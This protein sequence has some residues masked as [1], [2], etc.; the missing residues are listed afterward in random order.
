MQ[1]GN[2]AGANISIVGKGTASNTIINQ[3]DGMDRVFEQD[4]L[5]TGNVAVSISNVTLTGARPPQASM[6]DMAAAPFLAA[7]PMA[8]MSRLPTW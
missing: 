4:Q 2:I 8:T 7:A 5:L 3:T 1:V 6:P